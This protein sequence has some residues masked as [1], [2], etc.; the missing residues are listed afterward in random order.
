MLVSRAITGGLEFLDD[1]G[2]V[3][4]E[5]KQTVTGWEFR[6]LTEGQDVSLATGY[7]MHQFNRVEGATTGTDPL[8]DITVGDED[9]SFTAS[10]NLNAVSGSGFDIFVQ[11]HWTDE[12]GDAQ[13]ENLNTK[14]FTPG[15]QNGAPIHIRAKAGTR[16]YVAVTLSGSA[17]YNVE[18]VVDQVA[19]N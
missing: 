19:S 10:G 18:A 13:T 6:S 5:L 7:K 11:L 9:T 8:L 2:T 16:L 15:V 1:S 17:T 3:V 14:S 4:A 12:N